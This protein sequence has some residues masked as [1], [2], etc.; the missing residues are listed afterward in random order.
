MSPALVHHHTDHSAS[1]LSLSV[2]PSHHRETRLPSSPMNWIPRFLCTCMVSDSYPV[3]TQSTTDF[4]KAPC[5]RAQ[6]PLPG[7]P[8]ISLISRH[9]LIMWANMFFSSH[10]GRW[11]YVLL[12][13]LHVFSPPS[14]FLPPSSNH[15]LD[16]KCS[17]INSMLSI[18]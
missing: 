7:A 4:R 18:L 15:L 10:S 3:H 17:D 9:R 1:F 8:Q 12:I 14:G 11:F 5:S 16:F 6:Y 13:P 2:S